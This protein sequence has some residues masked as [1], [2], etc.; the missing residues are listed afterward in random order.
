MT[1]LLRFS[2][3]A[4]VVLSF[5]QAP[6]ANAQASRP[7]V[8][9]DAPDPEIVRTDDHGYAYPQ[10]GWMVVKIEGAPF[11]RGR[12]HGRLLAKEIIDFMHTL[13]RSFGPNEADGW[14]RAR[15]L[16]DALFLRGYDEELLLEMK[17][18][19]EGVNVVGKPIWGLPFLGRSVDLLD[20]AT[21]NSAIELGCLDRAL[22][23]LPDATDR[24]RPGG[25]RDGESH[26]HCSAF[27]ATGPATADG[28]IVFGHIT[29]WSL[30]EARSFN[31]WLDVSPKKGR[32]FCM[33]TYPG[34]VQ[35]GMD[36]YMNDAGIL[37]S[38]TTIVQT[39]FDAA[40]EPLASRIRR[41]AQYGESIDDVVRI[42]STKN[43]GLYTNEWLIGDTKTDE[44]A[45][46]ELGTQK[47]KLWRSSK[48]EW[49]GGTPGFYWG[50]NNAKDLEVRLEAERTLDGPP[51]NLVWRPMDRDITWCRLYAEAK[52]KIDADFGFKAFSTAPLVGSSSLDAKFTTSA[53]AKEMKSFAFFGPPRGRPWR[54]N[55]RQKAADPDVETLVPNEWTIL[56][57][58]RPKPDSRRDST[59]LDG[60]YG[61]S[62]MLY[63]EGSAEETRCTGSILPGA[64]R[65]L[66]LVAAYPVYAKYLANRGRT[67]WAS[68]ARDLIRYSVLARASNALLRGTPDCALEA[69]EPTPANGGWYDIMLARGFL[70]MDDLAEKIGSEALT[71][72]FEELGSAYVGKTATTENFRA[73]IERL[74]RGRSAAEFFDA[75]MRDT[76]P[77]KVLSRP[78]WSVFSFEEEPERALIVYGTLG[79]AAAHKDAAREL[80][81]AIADAWY[82]FEI[83]I[84]ADYE[85]AD[86][87][88]KTHHIVLVGPPDKNMIAARCR[89]Q[90]PV[91]FRSGW[92]ELEER[93][94]F[95]D[96]LSAVVAAGPNPFAERYSVVIY[97]GNDARSTWNAVHRVEGRGRRIDTWPNVIV[98]PARQEPVRMAIMP[99]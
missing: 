75:H 57:S 27:A 87:D 20:I 67:P 91:K 76:Q 53:M 93:G 77:L 86:D 21:I 97:A 34:G 68:N 95:G 54:P 38:E 24:T 35:S 19:A 60:S 59:R 58:A 33:Q 32:R 43:N 85:C 81:I 69:V 82:N 15:L 8:R 12:S 39:R 17:G 71:L 48:N 16:T 74:D 80:S 51:K 6:A 55:D 37:I 7:A 90:L 56:G 89:E 11:E 45:M 9:P 29:M 3:A 64:S 61:N 49:F 88:L 66:W 92:F 63:G 25:A 65:D 40:G 31:V 62:A 99:H 41:A 23:A 47:T 22:S 70:L 2:W 14:S 18:I 46:F 83:P 10:E 96:S 13:A 1:R 78:A 72:A 26:D 79:D 50:C 52:G 44:I 42:L 94:V 98:F 4:I 36:W 30:A 5:I 73:I 28:H 84:K